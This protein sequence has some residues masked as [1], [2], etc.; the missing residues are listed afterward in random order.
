MRIEENY[1]LFYCKDLSLFVFYIKPG[2]L[3]SATFALDLIRIFV[4]RALY[5]NIV[6][7]GYNKYRIMKQTCNI[8]HSNNSFYSTLVMF[9]VSTVAAAK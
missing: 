4:Y 7:S 1:F 3:A 6:I 2:K 8:L 5:C 9:R